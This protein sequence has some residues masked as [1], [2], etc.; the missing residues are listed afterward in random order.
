MNPNIINQQ[1]PQGTQYVQKT[2]SYAPPKI[3]P[4]KYIIETPS[5]SY[6]QQGQYQIPVQKKTQTSQYQ[7]YSTPV[8]YNYKTTTTT[9]TTTATN[10]SNNIYNNYT[11]DIERKTHKNPQN[12]KITENYGFNMNNNNN[13]LNLQK[14]PSAGNVMNYTHQIQ[15]KRINSNIQQ[16]QNYAN[17][18]QNIQN[19]YKVNNNINN[20]VNYNR[21]YNY[22]NN[23]N[24]MFLVQIGKNYNNY[25]N[26][27]Q[28]VNPNYNIQNTKMQN[29]NVQNIN[30]NKYINYYSNNNKPPQIQPI[31][32]TSNPNINQNHHNPNIIINNNNLHHHQTN[33]NNINLNNLY[34]NNIIN[35]I[36]QQKQQQILNNNISNIN[37]INQK[38]QQQQI[39]NNNMNNINNINKLNTPKIQNPPIQI[40]NNIK[41]NQNQIPNQNIILN[42]QNINGYPPQQQKIIQPPIQPQIKKVVPKP[43]V[44]TRKNQM[45]EEPPDNMRNRGRHQ[46]QNNEYFNNTMPIPKSNKEILLNENYNKYNANN[47][48]NSQK[49][50]S[51]QGYTFYSKKDKYNFYNAP[52][53]INQLCYIA[54]KRP[55]TATKTP[56]INNNNIQSNK[57]AQNREYIDQYGNILV[58]FNGQLVDK[59]LLGN[60]KDMNYQNKDNVFYNEE[61]INNNINAN[62]NTNIENNLFT[63]TYPLPG[64]KQQYSTQTL[65]NNNDINNINIQNYQN[66]T[67]NQRNNRFIEQTDNYINNPDINNLFKK[68]NS[69]QIMQ[70]EIKVV[71]PQKKKKRPVFKIPP[72]KKRAISQGRS[73]AFIHKYYDENFILEEDEE[74]SDNEKKKFKNVVKEV[75]NIRRLIPKHNDKKEENINDINNSKDNNEMNKNDNNNEINE[76]ININAEKNK[77]EEIMDKE[78]KGEEN[79][80][81]DNNE[82]EDDTSNNN[83]VMRLSHIGFSLEK[84]NIMPENTDNIEENK[85]NKDNNNDINNEIIS[86]VKI[87]QNI[88]EEKIIDI[89]ENKNEESNNDNKKKR[90]IDINMDL[91]MNDNDIDNDNLNIDKIDEKLNQKIKLYQEEN[92]KKENLENNKD[93]IPTI[94]KNLSGEI[95]KPEKYDLSGINNTSNLEKPKSEENINENNSYIKSNQDQNQ[96]QESYLTDEKIINNNSSISPNLLRDSDMSNI[97]PNFYE[98]MKDSISNLHF[99]KNENEENN[100]IN[101][102]IE[103]HDLDKYFNED[104]NK[105][106]REISE[107]LR[108]INSNDEY[109]N[110]QQIVDNLDEE[111]NNKKLDFEN[112]IISK[113]SSNGNNNIEKKLNTVNDIITGKKQISN[114][115]KSFN[116]NKI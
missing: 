94:P 32:K 91:D 75:I 82:N 113:S 23:D 62:V 87:D 29:T 102:N 17:N 89:N 95:S 22:E 42:N 25:N 97:N 90:N 49:I 70:Q 30:N 116:N 52:Q 84:S 83:N 41:Q 99:G 36:N 58:L 31:I 105:K 85:E 86:N 46:N 45:L 2:V 106:E 71:E 103:E 33:N 1:Y 77:K 107:S 76:N 73:L 26:N 9:T 48:V 66:Q 69:G 111:E 24:N 15:S 11:A 74:N 51:N 12:V 80:K 47:V 59:R 104:N 108:T 20:N 64:Q 7:T 6:P 40:N 19:A 54:P 8:Y 115:Y 72:S 16:N 92:N 13:N 78:D 14:R 68:S 55:K 93:E 63:N 88:Y 34:N 110:S 57:I 61:L 65:I 112:N 38:K 4:T 60:N 35:N 18:T 98:P 79:I 43:I 50:I 101:M 5:Y 3:L 39:I 109:R 44:N 28:I 56:N 96:K 100:R 21:K 37:N 10:N 53:R 67:Y 114:S 81:I 27:Q